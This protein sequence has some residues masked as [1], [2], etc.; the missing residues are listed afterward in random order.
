MPLT[1]KI[2]SL[3]KKLYST[4]RLFEAAKKRG[5]NVEVI[6]YLKCDLVI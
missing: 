4:Q 6:D 3:S 1:I 2:L 5:H